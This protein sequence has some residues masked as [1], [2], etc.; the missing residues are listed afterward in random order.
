MAIIP[1]RNKNR[2]G[3]SL[4]P[5]AELRTEMDRLFESFM[6]EP[7]GALS[8]RFGAEVPWVPSIDV[9]ENDKEVTVRAELPGIDPKDLDITVAGN[10]LM[11]AGEKKESSEKR[12]KQ[13]YQVE[14]RYGAFRRVI[15]LPA[16]VDADQVSA[17][18]D[19][20]VLTIRLKKTK[21]ERSKR[22]E[23]KSS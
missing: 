13:F 17:G 3:G 12:D 11:L 9:A 14:S 23:V 10:R 5:L 8:E 6:R 4:A 7:F 1:W 16:D 20:G 21:A 19:N 15:E 22:I 18:Y 2:D